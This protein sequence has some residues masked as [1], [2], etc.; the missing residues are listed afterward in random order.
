MKPF[1]GVTGMVVKPGQLFPKETP[2][3]GSIDVCALFEDIYRAVQRAGGIPVVIPQTQDPDCISEL[4][5]RLDGVLIPGGWDI[6]PVF[7]GEAKC[8][9]CGYA[10]PEQDAFEIAL[11]KCAIAAKKPVFGICRGAQLLNIASGGTI[12]QDL[13]EGGFA[14][15]VLLEGDIHRTPRHPVTFTPEGGFGELFGAGEMLVNSMHHQA[16]KALGP[17]TVVAAKAPDGVIEGIRILDAHPFTCG[18]Q[19]HPEFMPDSPEQAGLFKAFVDAC[20]G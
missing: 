7:Y 1:I 4:L 20:R 10:V 5:S 8:E 18:V 14:S 3:L 6:D 2:V 11:V 15:H 13:E 12:I 19:W 16:I 17:N 9:K